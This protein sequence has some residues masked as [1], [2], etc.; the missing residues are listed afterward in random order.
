MQ[1]YG[2]KVKIGNQGTA[3]D[4]KLDVEGNIKIRGGD[5]KISNGRGIDFSDVAGS[6]SGSASAL[7]DDYEEGSYTPALLGSTS[8]PTVNYT[9]QQ[10]RY[11]KIGN[12]MY[13]TFDLTYDSKSADG[14]GILYVSLPFSV[15]NTSVFHIAHLRGSRC[16]AFPTTVTKFAPA[17]AIIPGTSFFEPNTNNGTGGFGVIA[18]SDLNSSGRVVGG[19][20]YQV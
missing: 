7:L 20:V 14:S 18:G 19:A 8:N 6:A 16:T 17:H 10:G 3:P 11:T 4:E 2:G 12:L 15:N 5:L 1:G 13:V 9:N